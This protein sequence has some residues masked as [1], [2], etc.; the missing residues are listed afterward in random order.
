MQPGQT[1]YEAHLA[2]IRMDTG[3]RQPQP[4]WAALDSDSRRHWAALEAADP[5]F[6]Q[7]LAEERKATALEDTAERLGRIMVAVEQALREGG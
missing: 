5:A 4:T 2:R 7:A 1:F 3:V 6:R